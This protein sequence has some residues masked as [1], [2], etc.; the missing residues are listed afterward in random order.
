MPSIST[1]A[2]M[3]SI[4]N[5]LSSNS[6]VHDN[7][8][9]RRHTVVE[10]SDS[11]V[12]LLSEDEVDEDNQ[13]LESIDRISDILA[14]L[15]REANDA[16]NGIEKEKAQLRK[17]RMARAAG[18][19]PRPSH[20]NSFSTRPSRLPRP[21]KTRSANTFNTTT[22]SSSPTSSSSPSTHSF[23]LLPP[24][25]SASSSGRPLSCPTL[26]SNKRVLHEPLLESFKRL[27]TSMALVDSL[28]RDLASQSEMPATMNVSTTRSASSLGIL[29]LVP[30]LHIPHVLITVIF[31]TL[32]SSTARSSFN[33]S[34]MIAWACLFA[35]GN[36]MVSDAV[37]NNELR[38]RRVSLPGSYNN[39]N[40][41]NNLA[42]REEQHKEEK[43]KTQPQ[44]RDTSAP[45]TNPPEMQHQLRPITR[46]KRSVYRR[47]TTYRKRQSHVTRGHARQAS[48][49]FLWNPAAV[50]G[51]CPQPTKDAQLRR[52][53]SLP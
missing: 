53:N 18:L 34:G 19:P 21:V 42:G 7:R 11:A 2:F 25:T 4:N 43:E 29:F 41:N 35:L 3:P 6:R 26:A 48:H 50:N 30:L 22:L 15:I 17:A 8:S 27:D 13:H 1:P 44:Q 12:A 14:K 9:R 51:A 20:A 33:L 31:D 39:D 28:S 46:K 24:P 36:L 38:Q 16:V 47:S 37:S 52:R 45:A 10:R 40:N 49:S 5:T 23:D 32:N